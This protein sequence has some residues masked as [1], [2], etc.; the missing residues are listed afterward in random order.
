MKKDPRVDEY[1][2]RAQ[3]FAKPILKHLRKLVHT[4]CPEVEETMKWAMPSFEYKGALC[5]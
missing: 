5:G 1:I 3:P 4:A 2:D